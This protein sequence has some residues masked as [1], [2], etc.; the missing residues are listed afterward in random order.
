[1][2]M[3]E[4]I[5]LERHV[6]A[7]ALFCQC[8]KE[9]S[10]I[11]YEVK[12]GIDVNLFSGIR[13][14]IAEFINKNLVAGQNYETI[15]AFLIAKTYDDKALHEEMCQILAT[16]TLLRAG[17]YQSVIKEIEAIISIQ[18]IHRGLV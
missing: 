10:E 14:R 8:L 15:R 12:D 9:N 17:S 16:N 13:I 7:S 3:G 2:R 5:C 11:Y 4:K 6:L 1:M 18:N